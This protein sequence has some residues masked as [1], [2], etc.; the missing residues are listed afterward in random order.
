LPLV[1]TV[2]KLL[3]LAA[4][5]GNEKKNCKCV[6]KFVI[7]MFGTQGFSYVIVELAQRCMSALINFIGNELFFCI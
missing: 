7:I 2:R 6:I 1:Q 4:R 5:K 3:G